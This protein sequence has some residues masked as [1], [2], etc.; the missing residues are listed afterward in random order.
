MS[1]YLIR[2][3]KTVVAVV[4]AAAVEEAEVEEHLDAL[5]VLLFLVSCCNNRETSM[6]SFIK[7][8]N[9]FIKHFKFQYS[10]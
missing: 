5:V 1:R 8:K 10:F 6:L 2:L 9:L 4:A 7:E 3:P